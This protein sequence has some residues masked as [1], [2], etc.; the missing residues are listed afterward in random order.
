MKFKKILTAVLAAAMTCSLAAC[1]NGGSSTPGS[2]NVS[3]DNSTQLASTDKVL[4]IGISKM[5]DH[6]AMNKSEKGFVDAL[7]SKGYVDGQNIKI[8]YQNGQGETSNLNTI[9]TQFVGNKVDLIF[10]IATPAAQ[11]CFGQTTE[12]P[13]IG[14][15][16]TDF[17]DAGLVNDN[18]N[19]G[20]NVSGTTDMNPIEE[21][22]DLLLELFP[23]TGTIGFVYTASE[24][25]SVLQCKLAKEY[26]ESKGLTTTEKTIINTNDI[27]QAVSSIVTECDALYLPTDN[28][29]A[30]AMSL[31][32]SVC[33]T[34]KIPVICGEN[35]M[36]E[37]GGF[38]TLSINYYDLGFQAGLMA[39]EVL[40]GADISKMAIQK[41]TNYEY[42]FN[43]D[44]ITAL[45]ITLPDKYK[46]FV[47]ET[48]SAE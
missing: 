33:N 30:S 3:T 48:A 43:E 10:A 13:I 21:Q 2:G 45:G 9:A 46:D 1:G 5:M 44:A 20:T 39:V 17:A 42:A 34:E 26:I 18:N 22:I 6:T 47:I 16:I 12:I 29:I 8:D 38:G 36:V 14:T 28:Q 24:Q 35:G 23:D 7:E 27:Q 15:A 31:V 40:E 11:A 19:P 41:S 37:N 4:N 25:N 32:S